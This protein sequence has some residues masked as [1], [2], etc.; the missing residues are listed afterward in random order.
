MKTLAI[1]DLL[2]INT[3]CTSLRPVA[4]PEQPARESP[5][6][7]TGLQIGQRVVIVTNDGKRHDMRITQLTDREI[8]GRKS[9]ILLADVAS[10]HERRSSPVRTTLLVLGGIVAAVVL[11]ASQVPYTGP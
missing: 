3:A 6:Y 11:A 8:V 9:T 7:G 10:V 1:I 5:A 4:F 2:L